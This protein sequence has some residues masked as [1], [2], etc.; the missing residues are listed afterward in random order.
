MILLWSTQKKDPASQ[1]QE[2]K[3]FTKGLRILAIVL[4]IIIVF[5]QRNTLYEYMLSF[6][7]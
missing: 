2:A 3:K 4:I 5:L 1:Y 7:S 6:F